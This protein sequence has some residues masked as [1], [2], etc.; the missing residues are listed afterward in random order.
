M[1]KA[2]SASTA[3]AWLFRAVALGGLVVVVRVLLGFATQWWPTYAG[4]PRIVLFIG[5]LAAG[6]A[7]GLVDGRRDREAHPDPDQGD[8]LTMMWLKAAAVAGVGSGAV[9]WLA[10]QLPK[11]DVGGQSLVFE[12]TSGAA[13]IVLVV[14]LTALAGVALGRYLVTRQADKN[15]A[16]LEGHTPIPAP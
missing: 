5:V 7:W 9:S 8:D 3:P 13:F 1:Q 11:I 4:I 12:L 15:A 14:F 2:F 16:V 6:V 10:G